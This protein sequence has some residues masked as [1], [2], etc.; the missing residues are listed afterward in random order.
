MPEKGRDAVGLSGGSKLQ[1]KGVL[2]HS[3]EV[4][5]KA[6]AVT[7][8]ILPVFI[9]IVAALLAAAP[10]TWAIPFSIT[11]II[12]EV[13]ASAGDAGIQISVDAGGWER[14]LVFDPDGQKIFDVRGSGS[15]G[16]QGVTELFFES[17][18]PSFEEQTLEELFARFPEGNYTF[19]GTTVDGKTLNGRARLRHNIPAGPEIVFPAEGEALDPDEPVVISWE[20]VTDP[21]PD[22][23]L[24]VDTVGYQV[25]VER[26]KPQPLL[27]YSV[28]LPASV[29]EVTVS[30]EF[31]E[32]NADY[33]F[34]VLAIEASGNQTI[35]EGF[36]V[37]TP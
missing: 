5:K 14:L 25:I 24:A 21:F 28:T 36:F 34:E 10:N 26:V 6:I 22:T 31:L 7:R 17:A 12:I 18:E 30:P 16:K 32:A 23:D 8:H 13:N 2:M 11:K 20:P 15:V 4:G 35:T 9:L 27:V 19:R 29:T 1:Q 33:N 3:A 37:T